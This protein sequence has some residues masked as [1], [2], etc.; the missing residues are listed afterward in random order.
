MRAFL[1]SK[2]RFVHNMSRSLFN[3][4]PRRTSFLSLAA[5][6]MGQRVLSAKEIRDLFIFLQR[7]AG[8]I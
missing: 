8:L 1:S 2:K 5:V 3:F 4:R 7:E 6:M